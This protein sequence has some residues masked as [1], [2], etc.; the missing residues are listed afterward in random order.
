MT[1]EASD[2]GTGSRADLDA[3]AE[4]VAQSA[5]AIG[6]LLTTLDRLSDSGTLAALNAVLEEFDENFSAI[7]KPDFMTMVANGMMLLGTL[8][9]LSYEP[10]FNTA[11]HVPEV[12]NAE[13][14]AFVAQDAPSLLETLRLVR[15]PEL[16]SALRLAVA[17]LQAQR[18]AN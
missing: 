13:Y 7:N 1:T 14:P 10:F 6:E 3:L 11:M 2:P 18:R 8:S 9:E 17:I 16:R 4:R 5:P 12:M 15:S